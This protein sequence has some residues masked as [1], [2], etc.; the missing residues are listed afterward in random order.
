MT[1]IPH[2]YWLEKNKRWQCKVTINGDRKSFYSGTPGRKGQRECERTAQ[3]WIDANASHDDRVSSI[4]AEYVAHYERLGQEE[5]AIKTE[6]F[7][8]LYIIPVIG[9]RKL[10]TVRA[11][12]WQRIIDMQHERGLHKKTLTNIRGACRTFAKFARSRGYMCA[13]VV[14]DIPALSPTNPKR[15]VG[16]NEL[17]RLFTVDT[18]EKK[19][20][21]IRFEWAQKHPDLEWYAN[22]YRFI[23]VNGLRRG[24][25][26]GIR[27]EDIVGDVLLIRRSINRLQ[28][29]TGGKNENAPRRIGLSEISL[30]IIDRQ[31]AQKRMAGY[32]T[33]WLFPAPDGGRMD[34]NALYKEWHMFFAPQ[35]GIKSSLHELRH[36][37][38]SAVKSDMPLA[39]L[40]EMVGHSDDTDS[41]GIY[42]HEYDDD[43]VRQAEI[44]DSVFARFVN[45]PHP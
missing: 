34:T 44:V 28:K 12:D 45:N 23:V 24:E 20:H 40:Q 31:R 35:Q 38:I 42:G 4:W 7:G 37:F 39:L 33:P 16:S 6:S 9:S 18:V 26:S 13:D 8:R 21:P 36:T 25:A 1:P 41:L 15:I 3:A 5:T 30:D 43:L 11:Q 17:A 29:E 19:K 14:A 2:A 32:V 27:E 22:A 10:S